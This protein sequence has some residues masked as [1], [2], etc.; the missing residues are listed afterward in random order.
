M[1][2]FK[3]C[4]C[5]FLIAALALSLVACDDGESTVVPEPQPNKV[6]RDPAPVATEVAFVDTDGA[7]E[8]KTV[9]FNVSSDYVIIV[10]KSDAKAKKSANLIKAFYSDTLKIDLPI[11]TDDAPAVDKEIIVGKTN[12]TESNKDIK[13]SDLEVSVK[14][15][16][17]VFDGGHYITTNSA[18]EK[19]IRLAPEKGKACTFKLTTDFTAT[20]LDGYNYV[21]GDEFEGT[22]INLSKWD[23]EARMGGTN[24]IELSWGKDTIN[25]ADGRLKL[26]A[27]RYYNREKEGTQYRVP[28]STLTKYKMNYVYGYAEIRARLPFFG[29]AWPSFWA[30]SSELDQ[31]GKFNATANNAW[32][33]SIE[34]DIFEVFGHESQVVPAIHKWYKV[35][36][37]D[38]GTIH[39]IEGGSTHTSIGGEVA[40]DIPLWDWANE[41]DVDLKNLSN[42]YHL[43]GFE[44]TKKELNMFV[45]GKKYATFDISKS[46]DKY[47]DMSHFHDP[48]Y[49]MFNNHLMATDSTMQTTVINSNNEKLPA[50]YFIDW[51]RLYQKPGEG[52]LYIDETPKQY[53]G[54]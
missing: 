42:E 41:S 11:K 29:G 1:N 48:I 8:Y 49:L 13:E 17:L 16:K 27:I 31:N 44:W 53:E 43:Y 39:N 33:Y 7:F 10:P 19:F 2:K 40:G 34:I 12:R 45:D 50:E 21:W 28:Y 4:L 25:V 6:L 9:D 54:R 32:K 36:N 22:D 51:I 46:Y 20:V 23:F 26:N 14:G 37:Y 47:A 15:N 38:Y 5:A 35:N 24:S 52:K 30:V 18:V 3:R